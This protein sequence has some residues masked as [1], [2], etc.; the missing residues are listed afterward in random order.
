MTQA[1][2]ARFPSTATIDS[3]FLQEMGLSTLSLP[4]NVP[5][6]KINN[7][8]LEYLSQVSYKCSIKQSLKA[9]CIKVIFCLG[10][11]LGRVP[12]V[13]ISSSFQ[14][15]NPPAAWIAAI[16]N[17]IAF[18]SFIV[19][20]TIKMVDNT[21]LSLSTTEQEQSI[22][23][24]R[25]RKLSILAFN[26]LN[27]FMAQIPSLYLSWNYN[28][29]HAFMVG[30]NA[31]DI[32]PPVYSLNIMLSE[33]L[34]NVAFSQNQKKL[35]DLKKDLI[36]KIE[37]KMKALA[38]GNNLS[39]V[40]AIRN[41][42]L[43]EVPELKIGHFLELIYSES[44]VDLV[45]DNPC[46]QDFKASVA[47]LI[48]YLLLS[49]Q[50]FWSAFLTYK[51]VGLVTDNT[52]LN[53]FICLYVVICNIALTRFVLVK[54]TY[55]MVNSLKVPCKKQ[56]HYSY[57]CDRIA[58][59]SGIVA[60]VVCI[61]LASCSF[62]HA[63]KLS[64]DFLPEAFVAPSAM[65][66][67]LGLAVMNYLPLRELSHG[68]TV[69]LIERFGSEVQQGQI[70]AYTKLSDIKKLIESSSVDSLAFFLLKNQFQTMVEHMLHKHGL[71][72]SALSS[73][74]HESHFY[75]S[76]VAYEDFYNR[77]DIY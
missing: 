19:W 49:V 28:P 39:F 52:G 17:F 26:T 18:S 66:Y 4:L 10:G 1:S 60:K 53:G 21:A 48:G 69:R 63:A 50:V 22:T 75:S 34:S 43:I 77:G 44:S 41:L 6:S 7:Y 14:S 40:D 36:S 5:S 35:V 71:D 13:P 58:P 67:G 47:Q 27:G 54:S 20:S 15:Q 12:L 42:V 37:T 70:E 23:F 2:Y 61:F 73:F 11:I 29:G 24:D 33:K 30:F 51:G 31:L 68:L 72:H 46:V 8:I 16:S 59:L 55:L 64:Q 45:E 65:T 9:R 38:Q 25:C 56:T 3:S 74:L 57:I 32:V 62:I 76:T